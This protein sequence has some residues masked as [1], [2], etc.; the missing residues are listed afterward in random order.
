MRPTHSEL[1]SAVFQH[2]TTVVAPLAS[3]GGPRRSDALHAAGLL[4]G[5]SKVVS[6]MAE[7]SLVMFEQVR[8]SCPK[9]GD[10]Q[11]Q[12]RDVIVS[13]QPDAMLNTYQFRCPTCESW[14]IRAAGP[15]VLAM[16]LRSGA[17]VARL[18]QF[19]AGSGSSSG[20]IG[21]VELIEFLEK[22]DRWPTLGR[23]RT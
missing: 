21:D 18:Q 7:W 19:E 13:A 22:L 11:V 6:S 4:L 3:R 20:P 16:L 15:H 8:V 12:A 10:A 9:C 1:P 14:T 23:D 17:K 5:V 2:S